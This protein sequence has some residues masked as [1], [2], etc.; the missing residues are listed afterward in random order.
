[1]GAGTMNIQNIVATFR[2]L[3]I[4]SFILISIIKFMKKAIK[5]DVVSNNTRKIY[6]NNYIL[7]VDVYLCFIFVYI[8][9]I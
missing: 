1:M 6:K 7:Y 5:G 4:V 9:N 2:L 3:V 8:K